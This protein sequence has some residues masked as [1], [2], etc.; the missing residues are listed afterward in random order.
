[1][2]KSAP[3]A[4]APVAPVNIELAASALCL[5]AG[6]LDSLFLGIEGPART[7]GAGGADGPAPPGRHDMLALSRHSDFSA[8]RLAETKPGHEQ[9]DASIERDR[10]LPAE[11]TH[12]TFFA[13][14]KYGTKSD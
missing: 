14:D 11:A 4:D 13:W 12:S 9:K 6:D 5:F 10:Q 1:M 2:S 8:P 3:I 7:S